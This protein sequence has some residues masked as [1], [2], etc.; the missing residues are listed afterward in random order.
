MRAP[1][2]FD[3]FYAERRDRLLT[4]AYCLTGDLSSARSA[5]RDA[6]VEAWQHRRKVGRLDDPEAWVRV[7]ACAHAQRRH[8]ARP[9]HRERGLDADVKATLDALGRLPAGQRRVL[10]L[11]QL[12]TASLDEIAREVGESRSDVERDLQIAAAQLA[13]AR[14]VPSTS[15]RGALDRVADHVR[16][17]VATHRW[18]RATIVRRAGSRRRRTRAAVAA[19]AA[20]AATGAVVVT[21]VVVTDTGGIRP[22]LARELGPVTGSGSSAPG[23]ADSSAAPAADLPTDA[24]LDAGV[25]SRVTPGRWTEASTSDGTAGDGIVMPCQAERYAD[26][27]PSAALVRAFAPVAPSGSPGALVVE[28]AEV[29]ARPAAAERAYR[30]AVSWFAGCRTPR[31]QLLD[32]RSVLGVGDEA[33]LLLLRTFDGAGSTVVAGVARTGSLTTTTVSTVPRGETAAPQRAARLL[34]DAVTGVCGLDGAGSCAGRP[35]LRATA[36]VPVAPV[37]AMLAEV[38]L[39]AAAGVRRPW[40]GTEP[41]A[42]RRNAA[43]TTCDRTDF[44]ARRFEHAATRTFLVPGARVPAQFGLTETVGALDEQGAAALVARV[45]QQMARCPDRL[46]GTHVR[47]VVDRR[48]HGR[49]IAVWHV[50]TAISSHASV[51][52]LMGVARSGRS[53]AQ[54]GFVPAPGASLSPAAFVAVVE[55]AQERLAAMPAGQ[56]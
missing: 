41:R 17:A 55:R 39:P 36:P 34:A 47:T 2:E 15:I 56:G 27:H 25:V 8:T 54:V 35:Q 5:V 9:W 33:T 26:P 23:G 24:M 21:G 49:D 37:P 11:A 32:T 44:S 18:P 42:P 29:S 20:V 53:V 43:A 31:A 40:V 48:S 51:D 16:A 19:V 30:T 50:S 46:L 45:R 28:A 7:R 14:D 10:L 12:T 22:T 52:F 3:R 13:V 4:L 6:F 38:D 1:D